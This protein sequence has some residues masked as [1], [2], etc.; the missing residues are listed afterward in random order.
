MNDADDQGSSPVE[1]V[2]DPDSAPAT[3][4]PH[5]RTC[6][7]A[8]SPREEF[9]AVCGE[10][11]ARQLDGRGTSNT[12][13]ATWT[14]IGVALIAIVIAVALTS[15]RPGTGSGGFSTAATTT[16]NYYPNTTTTQTYVS[17]GHVTGTQALL[18]I[19]GSND[20][21]Y[22][23]S[24]TIGLDSP[25]P[26]SSASTSELARSVRS[27]MTDAG[28]DAVIPIHLEEKN[29]TTSFSSILGFELDIG[30]I[31][32]TSGNLT[33]AGDVVFS[34]GPECIDPGGTSGNKVY[35]VQWNDPIA[36]GSSASDDFYLVIHNYYSPNHPSGDASDLAQITLRPVIQFGDSSGAGARSVSYGP[37]VMPKG[38]PADLPLKFDPA[39]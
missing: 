18:Q 22:S 36:A 4:L 24:V 38:S 8:M 21:G 29:A 11:R 32:D 23:A 13:S 12:W 9:C 31:G 17:E 20:E 34:A 28:T 2:K 19:D 14:V 6:G 15:G 39:A 30:T 7:T 1:P 10:P 16:T 25:I 27:C 26:V 35:G 33:L 3:E 5:C 37:M